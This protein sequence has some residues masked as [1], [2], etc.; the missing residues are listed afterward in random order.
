MIGSG[1]RE[2]TINNNQYLNV[3]ITEEMKQ[4]GDVIVTGIYDRKASSYT[5]AAV[6]I[7][8]AEL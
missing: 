1:A 6:T 4:L 7:T 8:K 3:V 5:G 2:I